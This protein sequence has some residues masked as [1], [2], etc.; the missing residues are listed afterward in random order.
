MGR[1]IKNHWARLIILTASAYQI[2][3]AIEGFIWP[4]VFWDFMTLNL[5][6]AVNPVPVL[7]ILNLLLG[8]LG[9][10]WEWPLKY[11]AGSLAHRSIEFRLIFYPLSALLSMLLYQG[12]D[13]AL[14]YVIGIGVYFWA[15][16]EGEVVCPVPWTLPKRSEYKSLPPRQPATSMPLVEDSPR[17]DNNTQ[18]PPTTL[19]PNNEAYEEEHDDDNDVPVNK[20]TSFNGRLNQYFHT[21]KPTSSAPPALPSTKQTI[22]TTTTQP[23]RTSSPLKRKRTTP[24]TST[25]TRITRSRSRSSTS[26]PTST[27]SSSPRPRKPPTTP[28]SASSSTSLLTDTIPPNLTLLLVGVNPGILTGITGYAYAHP[29]NLFWKL[30]HWSGITPIRHPP[31]DTY[32]LPELYNI[33]NT[34]IVERPT[35]DASMLS[36]K[37][38]DAGVPVLEAKVREKRP[39]AVCLVGKSIWE[40]VWRVKVGRGIRKEEFRYGWQD[41]GMNLGRV[42]G[43]DGGWEGARVFVATTTSGL[44]AGMSVME[45]REVWDE[46]GRWVVERRKVWEMEKG[47]D[48]D[49]V[50]VE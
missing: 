34:N 41:E 21:A 31:S 47:G 23:N 3:A 13:P 27:T 10:A 16:S 30:L 24:P 11:V 38:M 40:A 49:G 12:T 37:E 20:K 9:L 1:L 25:S 44:A 33:G 28:S 4:K 2:G 36:K 5:N 32:K 22:T 19:N 15:Y 42:G 43:D 50:K 39:E 14:Y 26:T 7:Q 6:G 18:I 48:G 17:E 8:L 46:L 45:K 29:S 35:R